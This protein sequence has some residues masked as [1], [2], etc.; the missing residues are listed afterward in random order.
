MSDAAKTVTP[1]TSATP[2]VSAAAVCAVRD[3]LR[4]AF[5]RP[6]RPASPMPRHRG[7]DDPRE[8]PRDVAREHRGAEEQEH[9]AEADQDESLGQAALGRQQPEQDEGDAAARQH[10]RDGEPRARRPREADV[11]HRGDRR[12]PA[13]LPGGHHRGCDGHDGPHDEARDD[14]SRKDAQAG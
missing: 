11:L 10:D 2:I 14:R 8:G 4:I 1:V 9:R 3:G 6:S 12:H 5:A 7:A 13:G